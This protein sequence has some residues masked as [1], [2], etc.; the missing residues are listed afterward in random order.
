MGIKEMLAAKAAQ[1]AAQAEQATPQEVAAQPKAPVLSMTESMTEPTTEHIAQHIAQH[2]AQPTTQS[3]AQPTTQPTAQ[4]QP[5][6][7]AVAAT[8]QAVA[9]KPAPAGPL[10]DQDL[11]KAEIEVFDRTGK[12]LG[13]YSLAS[14]KQALAHAQRLSKISPKYKQQAEVLDEALVLLQEHIEQYNEQAQATPEVQP[15][16][17]VQE[18]TGQQTF[19]LSIALNERQLMA[20]DMALSGKSFVLIGAAGTGKT[21]CQREV[22]R[23][24]WEQ[25]KLKSINFSSKKGTEDYGPSFA[26]VAF[27]RRAAANLRR[28]IH[29]DPELA[30]IFITNIRTIHSLLEYEPVYFTD[31]VTQKETMRFMPRRNAGNKL[32]ITHLVVEEASMVGAY[33]LWAALYEALPEGVQIIFIG[34]INQLTPVFG[35]SILNY[36][37]IQLPVIEL[38]HVYRQAGDSGILENA[39]R[40]LRGEAVKPAHDVHIVTGKNDQHVSQ[41]RTSMAMYKMFQDMFNKGLYD[42]EQDMILSPYNEQPLG[43]KNMN[44]W[45]AQFLGEHRN[46]VVHHVIA[47]FNQ[48]YLAVGDKVMYDKQDAIITKITPNMRYMGKA[49]MPAS[50]GLSRFGT[51]TGRGHEQSLDDLENQPGYANFSLETIVEDNQERKMSASHLVDIEV[52]DTGAKLTLEAAGD[53]GPQTFQLGYVLT[54][55][56]A[57]GCEWRHVFILF[58][59]AHRTM[60]FREWLYTAWTRAAKGLWV[61]SKQWL[62]DK[63]VLNPRIKGDTLEDKIAYFNSDLGQLQGGIYAYK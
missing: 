20:R 11:A 47:G 36:A 23:A 63:A 48:H 56:K 46:A 59:P 35:P 52:I 62:L 1:Q 41:E 49:P 10:S 21:T 19:S 40:I 26:A 7:E 31:D 30:D 34:D 45:I 6:S 50:T 38:N 33:D 27:T 61:F 17:Q 37:L 44:A 25:G 14:L 2:M 43:T 16:A 15:M 12:S 51:H 32:E 60:I 13:W 28:A 4:A 57:Q 5:T 53:F 29:K 54:G 55:H 18:A 42:P 8:A 58:H 24:L 3:I 22:A 9:T 39:H